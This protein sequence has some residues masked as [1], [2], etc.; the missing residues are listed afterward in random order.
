MPT[1]WESL[2]QQALQEQDDQRRPGACGR[3]R[4]AIN[5]RLT[6]LAAE[7]LTSDEERERLD[8]ALRRLVIHEYKLDPPA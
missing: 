3:A 1:D 5:D 6:E 4:R 7:G 8:E 2:Y